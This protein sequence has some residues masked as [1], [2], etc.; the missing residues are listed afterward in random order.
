M[1]ALH[2]PIAVAKA[3]EC[4]EAAVAAALEPILTAL[5]QQGILTSLVAVG[6]LATVAVECSFKPICEIGDAAYFKQYDN[7][8]RLG[9]VNPGDGA[10]FKGRG[11]IQLTGRLHYVQAGAA[12]HLDLVGNPD[13][14]LQIPT[15]AK[16]LAWYFH[17]WGIAPLCNAQEWK[18]VREGVNGGDNGLTRFLN[19]VNCLLKLL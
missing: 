7:R 9:N 1:S 12:L 3:C 8:P 13:M 15:A 10:K 6:A 14:A 5:Q 2:D 17:Q 16:I 19:A 18:Q 11:F 4:D